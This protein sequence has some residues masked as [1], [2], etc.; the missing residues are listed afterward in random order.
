MF[1]LKKFKTFD[2]ALLDQHP[3]LKEALRPNDHYPELKHILKFIPGNVPVG[4]INTKVIINDGEII[5]RVY[6]TPKGHVI[7]LSSQS[8]DRF[9][10]HAA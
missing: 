5:E 10:D 1:V 6:M 4:S 9:S 2:D 8:S 3:D 7:S